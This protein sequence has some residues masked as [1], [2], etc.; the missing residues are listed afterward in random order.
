MARDGYLISSELVGLRPVMPDDARLLYDCWHDAGVQRN[1]NIQ[2]P[3]QPLDD[4]WRAENQRPR[5][6]LECVVVWFADEAPA[7]I[8]SLGSIKADPELMVLLLPGFRGRGLGTEASRLIIDYGFTRMGIASVGGGASDFNKASQRMLAKLGF[9]RDPA[10]DASYNNEW[11][12]GSVTELAYHLD[13]TDWMRGRSFGAPVTPCVFD[14]RLA[15]ETIRGLDIVRVCGSDGERQ[16]LETIAGRLDR[17]GVT[18]RYHTFRDAWL[19]PDD[20]HLVVRGRKI[21]VRPVMELSFQSGF[22]FMGNDG[23]CVEVVA[24]LSPVGDCAGRIAVAREFDSSR[25]VE[26]EAAAQ[27]MA[28]PFREDA[29]AYL[30]AQT[31]GIEKVPSAYVTPED[32][33]FVLDSLGEHAV[34]RWGARK[35]EREFRNLVAEI[36]GTRKPEE[37]VVMG[38][39]IDSFPGTVGSAD[40]AAGCAL[41]VEAARWF[42]ANPPERTVRLIW[43]TGEELDRRGSRRYASECI[44]GPRSAK[45]MVNVDTG[46]EMY[47]GPVKVYASREETLAWAEKTLNLRGIETHISQSSYADAGAFS[48]MGIPTLMACA[49]SKQP[50]H[51]PDD[52]PG[53][54]D[55]HKLQV[56]GSLSLQAAICA[57]YL[58]TGT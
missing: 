26:P 20:P 31:W 4:W 22:E 27:L 32:I 51:L 19:E 2:E 11:G 58:P 12:E 29:E 16:A 23:L 40:D 43:F 39:H 46:Y 37:I 24:P 21:S 50:A 7:G 10:A 54:I 47:T 17:I 34:L 53:N 6:W 44:G 52:R 25:P 18:W 3:D 45:L 55:P 13:R 48:E 36:P 41:L 1:L 15:L 5:S 30:W 28:F 38:A 42:A 49:P 56:I 33:A 8:V 35:T 14:A 57:A 9:V